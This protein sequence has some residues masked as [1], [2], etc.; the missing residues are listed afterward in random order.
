MFKHSKGEFYF[1]KYMDKKLLCFHV[2]GYYKVI[3]NVLEN[4]NKIFTLWVKTQSKESPRWKDILSTCIFVCL[5]DHKWSIIVWIVIISFG[6][7][8]IIFKVYMPKAWH[9][10]KV[11]LH[12]KAFKLWK[13]TILVFFKHLFFLPNVH[14][15]FW[16]LERILTLMSRKGKKIELMKKKKYYQFEHIW[17]KSVFD[18][19]NYGFWKCALNKSC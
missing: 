7:V 15:S 14:H 10:S 12:V 4:T 11:F 16:K 18:F 8:F 5:K 9:K 17:F 2:Y 19:E 3:I 6:I 1:S 13:S